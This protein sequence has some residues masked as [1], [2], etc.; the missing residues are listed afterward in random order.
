MKAVTNNQLN[1]P[2]ERD[3]RVGAY[4]QYYLQNKNVRKCINWAI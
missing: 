1:Q 2:H 4:L 3:N